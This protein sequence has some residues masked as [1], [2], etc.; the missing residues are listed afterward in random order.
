[1]WG[2]VLA[3]ADPVEEPGQVRGGELPVER[4][5]GLVVAGC[6]REQGT[7]EFIQAGKVVGRDDF[8]L[9]DREEDFVG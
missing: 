7:G 8:L 5:G 4:A 2:G 1:L 3:G 9:R 6:E